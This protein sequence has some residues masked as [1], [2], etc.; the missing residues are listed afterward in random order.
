MLEQC[1]QPADL[2]SMPPRWASAEFDA[3]C[4]ASWQAADCS[5]GGSI[6]VLG[7]ALQIYYQAAGASSSVPRSWAH[8]VERGLWGGGPP[9]W[10]GAGCAT[11]LFTFSTPHAV[12]PGLRCMSYSRLC[13]RQ[14]TASFDHVYTMRMPV[15]HRRNPQVALLLPLF[16]AAAWGDKPAHAARG[17]RQVRSSSLRIQPLALPCL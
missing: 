14:A 9:P 15:C 7:P 10:L 1:Q 13:S 2:R 17:R 5:F 8:A 3:R 16:L 12:E 6:D 11:A 4:T